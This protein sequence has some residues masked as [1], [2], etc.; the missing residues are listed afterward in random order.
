[1]GESFQCGRTHEQSK[2]TLC[3]P[4]CTNP[5]YAKNN[6]RKK[7]HLGVRHLSNGD[8]APLLFECKWIQLKGNRNQKEIYEQY[9]ANDVCVIMNKY[10][11]QHNGNCIVKDMNLYGIPIMTNIEWSYIVIPFFRFDIQLKK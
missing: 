7:L 4:S 6:I 1:M 11:Q 3:K 5:S 2:M 8:C 9:C 10:I